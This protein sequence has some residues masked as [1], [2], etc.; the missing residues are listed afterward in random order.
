MCIFPVI[1]CFAVVITRHVI[2]IVCDK[3][4]PQTEIRWLNIN[5]SSVRGELLVL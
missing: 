1:L 3:D 4:Q 2:C 5:L